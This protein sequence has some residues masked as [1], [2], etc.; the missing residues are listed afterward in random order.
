MLEGLIYHYHVIIYCSYKPLVMTSKV[1]LYLHCS[2]SPL[3]VFVYIKQN[4]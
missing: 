3:S 2:F 4:N 1:L